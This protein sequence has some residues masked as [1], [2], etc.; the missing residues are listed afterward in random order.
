MFS[1]QLQSLEKHCLHLEWLSHLNQ[2]PI[3]FH[4]QAPGVGFHG[5]PKSHQVNNQDWPSPSPSSSTEIGHFFGSQG[6]SPLCP[7]ETCETSS[8][9]L[10]RKLLPCVLS[11]EV[12]QVPILLPCPI[13]MALLPQH[14]PPSSSLAGGPGPTDPNCIYHQWSCLPSG[15]CS[16]FVPMDSGTYLFWYLLVPSSALW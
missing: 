15:P 3:T 2:P 1:P 14:G 12:L 13:S 10:V 9:L 6:W 5:D 8:E 16:A 4:S 7:L 11:P